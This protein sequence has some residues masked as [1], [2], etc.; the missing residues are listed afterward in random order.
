MNEDKKYINATT[1]TTIIIITKYNYEK[2]FLFLNNIVVTELILCPDRI[3]SCKIY[4][5]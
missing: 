3:L 2:P 5:L 4:W 1:N